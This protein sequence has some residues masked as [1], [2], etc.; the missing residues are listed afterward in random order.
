MKTRQR[1][2]EEVLAAIRQSL[3]IGLRAGTSSHRFIGRWA[4]VAEGRVFVRSWSLTP[5]GWYYALREEPRGTMQIAGQEI[6]VRAVRTRSE[7]LKDSVSRAYKE[8]YHTPASARY[9]KD[10]NGKKSR[11]TTLELAPVE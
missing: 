8:K 7:R 5:K 6:P 11:E 4:V 1:F 3:I 2:S 9:V 10:L